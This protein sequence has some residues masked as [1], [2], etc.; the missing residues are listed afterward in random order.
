MLGEW[1]Y[2]LQAWAPLF[3]VAAL[4]GFIWMKRRI[5]LLAAQ[6]KDN[7]RLIGILMQ[8]YDF[9][10]THGRGGGSAGR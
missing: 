1:L 5:D 4:I 7:E 2:D 9:L 6:A 3:A 10:S 8:K